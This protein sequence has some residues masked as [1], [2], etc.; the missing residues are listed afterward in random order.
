M[1]A[2]K[3]V[4]KTAKKTVTHKADKKPAKTGKKV[5][6]VSRNKN[7]INSGYLRRAV[8]FNPAKVDKSG[9]KSAKT[10]S[11]A[12]PSKESVTSAKRRGRKPKAVEAVISKASTKKVPRSAFIKELSELISINET[13]FADIDALFRK[14]AELIAGVNVQKTETASRKVKTDSI[15]NTGI[16][17]VPSKD[18]GILSVAVK[19]KA[20]IESAQRQNIVS[21]D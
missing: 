11:A 8:A 3:N 14:H 1:A 13:A 17:S 20:S 18:A 15:S 19:G 5:A 9:T 16:T 2:K 12:K 6:A 10:T 21:A 4:K 7:V